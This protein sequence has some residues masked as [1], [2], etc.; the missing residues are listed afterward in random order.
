MAESINKAIN[1]IKYLQELA[2]LRT[3]IV[4]DVEKYTEVLWLHEIP[5]DDKGRCFTQ[6]WR[7]E[8]DHN[9]DD[10]IVIKKYNEPIVPEPPKE[11]LQWIY[12]KGAAGL[13]LRGTVSFQKRTGLL[14]KV[15]LQPLSAQKLTWIQTTPSASRPRRIGHNGRKVA[16]WSVNISLKRQI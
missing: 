1:L 8:S 12:E 5:K 6:A 2:R 15:I 10:W 11:C 7:I 9:I 3:K 16:L 4:R 13:R 14:P